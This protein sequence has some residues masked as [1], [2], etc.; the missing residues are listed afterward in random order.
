LTGQAE[1]VVES[2]LEAIFSDPQ[3]VKS[4]RFRFVVREAD[5]IHM[6]NAPRRQFIVMLR[7]RCE[8][9]TSAGERRRFGPGDVLLAEDVDGFGHIT[10]RVGD[11]ERLTLLIPLE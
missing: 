10:R 2:D 3:A 1:G 11:E 5:D 9:E 6:H 8:V 7:G 4:I